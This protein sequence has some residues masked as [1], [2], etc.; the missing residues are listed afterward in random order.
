MI[1]EYNNKDI[2]NTDNLIKFLEQNQNVDFLVFNLQDEE[3]VSRLNFK[4]FKRKQE[5]IIFQLKAFQR[6]LRIIPDNN[7]EAALLLMKAG[8]HSALQV[9][10]MARKDFM[11]KCAGIFDDNAKLADVIYKNSL[12]KR[13]T[14]LIQ[15]MNMLQNGEPHISSA[16]FN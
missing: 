7:F 1:V 6:L 15:Y 2:I 4:N 8:I 14:I 9:A 16:R 13:S 10:A 3:N 12:D 11:R 5:E